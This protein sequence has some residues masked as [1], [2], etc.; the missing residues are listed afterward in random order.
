[1]VISKE[2]N[3][4]RKGMEEVTCLGDALLEVGEDIYLNSPLC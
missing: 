2:V 1:M 3:D 4:P